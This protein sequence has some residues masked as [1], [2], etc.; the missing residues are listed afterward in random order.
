MVHVIS[1]LTI[2][3]YRCDHINSTILVVNIFRENEINNTFNATRT[4]GDRLPISAFFTSDIPIFVIFTSDIPIFA[5]LPMS[6]ISQ[7]SFR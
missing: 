3:R 7:I 4:G 6:D 2:R 1:H 5:F